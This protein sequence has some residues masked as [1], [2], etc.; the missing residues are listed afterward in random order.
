MMA[1]DVGV[2]TAHYVYWKM[3]F[4]RL[5]IE[6]FTLDIPL[7]LYILQGNYLAGCTNTT[8]VIIITL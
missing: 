5:T 8:K 6:Y 2:E 7:C 3:S 1:N 4:A